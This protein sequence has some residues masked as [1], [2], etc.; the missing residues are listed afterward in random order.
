M[1]PLQ[2]GIYADKY[3]STTLDEVDTFFIDSVRA[4]L[5]YAPEHR[6]T[7]LSQ[8]INDEYLRERFR[9]FKLEFI[10]VTPRQH[11]NTLLD[12]ARRLLF[13]NKKLSAEVA[14]IN[15]LNLDIIS[16]PRQ[17]VPL[18]GLTAKVVLTLFDIQHEYLPDY[19]RPIDL[20]FRA[21]KYHKSIQLSDHIVAV[22]QF[23]ETTLAKK[24]PEK[25]QR[26]TTI[27]P[28]L[29]DGFIASSYDLPKIS[30]DIPEEFM[31]YPANPWI[32]KNHNRLF[33]ALR[34]LK[35]Q[36]NLIIPLVC[37]GRLDTNSPFTIRNLA[38]AAGV[39]E[40][41]YDLGFVDNAY[42]FALY[43]KA[44]AMVFPSLF[45]GFGFPILEAM[46]WACPVLSSQASSLP[47]VAGEAALYFDANN[48]ASIVDA[49]E[50]VWHDDAIRKELQANGLANRRR[51]SWKDYAHNTIALYQKLVK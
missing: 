22:S 6:Y 7:I 38:L 10:N 33:A 30:H 39:S 17:L 11:T 32:H 28:G 27:Y 14:Q 4:L 42:K 25:M 31:L 18:E 3:Q 9:A 15:S 8:D 20:E 47:E 24:Y 23:M 21:E 29:E 50:T 43:K 46:N 2:I 35:D 37:F 1:K 16:F 13:R 44:K 48:I 12:K 36:K 49:L 41:V 5:T 26:T 51:F 34:R 19:F 45:E 40:Q